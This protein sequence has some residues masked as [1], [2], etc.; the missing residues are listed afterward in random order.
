MLWSWVS[1][2]TGPSPPMA[3]GEVCL[4]W[5]TPWQKAGG[6]T[7]Y[8][9]FVRHLCVFVLSSEIFGPNFKHRALLGN[10]IMQAWAKQGFIHYS[11][12]IKNPVVFLVLPNHCH[13]C[14]REATHTEEGRK[15]IWGHTGNLKK[16]KKKKLFVPG[17]VWDRLL[18]FSLSDVS[19]SKTGSL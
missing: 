9:L 16:K 14:R 19:C 10:K 17:T 6:M 7:C 15:W 8:V 2:C 3:R 1:F 18:F 11:L 4:N 5:E 13:C 12:P